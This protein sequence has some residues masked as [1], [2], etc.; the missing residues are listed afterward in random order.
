MKSTEHFVSIDVT[1]ERRPIICRDVR[2][3]RSQGPRGLR[4]QLSSLA[5]NL[6]S[7]VEIPL[8][9]WMFLSVYSVC[10]R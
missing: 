8:K 2:P 10:V 4:Q 7:W 5:R 6:G 9:A 3:C 1:M